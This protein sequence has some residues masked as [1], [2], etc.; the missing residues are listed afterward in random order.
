MG[1]FK[2]SRPRSIFATNKISK[3]N[4]GR[5]KKRTPI[6]QHQLRGKRK[7]VT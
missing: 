1:I 7:A 6:M 5:K 3:K 4:E 2:L